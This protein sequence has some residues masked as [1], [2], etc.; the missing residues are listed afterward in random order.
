[1]VAAVVTVVMDPL[2]EMVCLEWMQQGTL[3]VLMVDQ[4]ALEVMV[5]M[6]LMAPTEEME[7]SFRSLFLRPTWICSQ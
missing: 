3:L 6:L 5:E 4:V 7:A 2:E 1:M